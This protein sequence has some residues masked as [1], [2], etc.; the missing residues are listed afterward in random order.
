MNQTKLNLKELE[1]LTSY[2][3]LK[4]RDKY[5]DEISLKNDFYWDIT[6]NEL[7]DTYVV[8]TNL[9]IGQISDDIQEL[10]RLVNREGAISHDLK[11]LSVLL[12]VLSIE[13]STI[14]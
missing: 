12:K 7:F 13:F 14:L 11:R 6:E 3:L 8:P 4:I 5:G 2:F 10:N 9:T 1:S